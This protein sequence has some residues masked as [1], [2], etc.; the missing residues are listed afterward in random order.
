MAHAYWLFSKASSHF[1]CIYID[2]I[3]RLYRHIEPF[4]YPYPLSETGKIRDKDYFQI[5]YPP[6]LSNF[7]QFL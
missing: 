7:P 5:A 4:C 1:I 2:S 3:G 6:P